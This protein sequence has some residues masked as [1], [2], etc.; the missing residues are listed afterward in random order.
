MRSKRRNRQ[1][2]TET[3]GQFLLKLAITIIL[4][5]VWLRWH[6]GLTLNGMILPPLPIGMIVG[7][8]MVHQFERYQID[9]KI[10]FVAL[11]IAA[12]MSYFIP[13]GI[14]I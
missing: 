3:D 13:S 1:T 6:Q 7:M 11:V 14:V 12:I 8:L 5:S 10:W 4:G 2:S 9:R